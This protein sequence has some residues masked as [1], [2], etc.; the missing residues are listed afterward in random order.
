MVIVRVQ[1]QKSPTLLPKNDHKSFRMLWIGPNIIMKPTPGSLKRYP[2]F[3]PNIDDPK[4][5][6]VMKKARMDKAENSRALCENLV[7]IM[8]Q[9][10]DLQADVAEIKAIMDAQKSNV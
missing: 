7:E 10:E 3:R 1:C 5:R 9:V 6:P 2:D 8:K 4:H